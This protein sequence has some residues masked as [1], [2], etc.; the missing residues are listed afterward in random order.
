MTFIFILGV[1]SS[2]SEKL[3]ENWFSVWAVSIALFSAALALAGVMVQVEQTSSEARELRKRKLQSARA[4]LPS[5][6]SSSCQT[7]LT[8]LK[9]SSLFFQSERN[10]ED[11]QSLAR[12]IE[13]LYFSDEVVT[14]FRDVLENVEEQSV[15]DRIEVMLRE[16][17]IHRSRTQSLVKDYRFMAKPETH[18]SELIIGWAF[19]YALT[20]SLFDFSRRK[21][22]G[23]E[24]AVGVDEIFNSFNVASLHNLSLPNSKQIAENYA[25]N[26]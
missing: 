4:F 20:S 7:I 16:F 10:E 1:D 8:G 26:S 21:S 13:E 2:I 19:V 11:A 14:V 6:L 24:A 23:I 15:S 18:L 12:S 25:T 3:V 22:E 5:A 17:Q 9:S